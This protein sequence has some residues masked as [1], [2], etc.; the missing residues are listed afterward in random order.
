MKNHHVIVGAWLVVS[1]LYGILLLFVTHIPQTSV[2]V[3]VNRYDLDKLIHLLA[4]ALLAWLFF[5]AI[6]P[7]KTYLRWTVIMIGL[8]LLAAVDEFTQAWMGRQ[9][10]WLDFAADV[11]GILG[12]YVH[13]VLREIRKR[14]NLTKES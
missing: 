10:S 3:D 2:P 11:I 5:R 6:R 9:S 8:I 14:N 13:H 1:C 4:Y 7:D 12:V